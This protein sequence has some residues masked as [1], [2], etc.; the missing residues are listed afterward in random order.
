M[1][2]FRA[3]VYVISLVVSTRTQKSLKKISSSKLDAISKQMNMCMKACYSHRIP[4]YMFRPLMYPSS[5][6]CITKDRY[7]EIVQKFLDQF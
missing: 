4:T 7:S 3:I 6:R 1:N 5:G 2:N